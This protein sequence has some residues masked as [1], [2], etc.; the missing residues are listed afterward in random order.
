MS[1]LKRKNQ[2]D[3]AA[4][5]YKATKDKHLRPILKD[6]N[7]QNDFPNIC[8]AMKNLVDTDFFHVMTWLGKALLRVSHMPNTTET[9]NNIYLA[10]KRL[11]ILLPAYFNFQPDPEDRTGLN[12]RRAAEIALSAR[13]GNGVLKEIHTCLQDNYHPVTEQD[14]ILKNQWLEYT[15]PHE[16][17]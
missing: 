17:D 5:V 11:K 6:T 12:A 13:K 3:I 10:F 2:L 8:I 4:L 1:F 7:S 14:K 15:T 9:Q 16:I